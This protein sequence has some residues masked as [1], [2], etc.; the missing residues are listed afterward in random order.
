[1]KDKM[2]FYEWIP[3]VFND[4]LHWVIELKRYPKSHIDAIYYLWIALALEVG[5]IHI[6]DWLHSGLSAGW[7]NNHKLVE[8]A[9]ELYLN[10]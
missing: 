10:V 5:P 6:D 7:V 9:V 2:I 8:F 4:C 1:M 3:L